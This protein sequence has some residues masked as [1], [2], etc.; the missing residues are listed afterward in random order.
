MSSTVILR[1]V[2][3]WK[4]RRQQEALRIRLLRQRDGDECRRCRRPMRFD[5]PEGQDV[6]AKVEQILSGT[7]SLD[8]LCLTHRRCNPESADVTTQVQE[9]VRRK[10]EAELFSKSRERRTA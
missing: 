4:F 7:D 6:G 10:S 8:N 9:R 5:L 2:N 3:P 1:Y